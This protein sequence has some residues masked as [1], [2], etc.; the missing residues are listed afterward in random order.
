VERQIAAGVGR[1]VPETDAQAL[2]MAYRILWRLHA[3]G[4]LLTDGVLDMDSIGE[5]GRAF[6]LQE[7]GAP[8][9]AA[10][11][12]GV[13]QAVTAAAAAIDRLVTA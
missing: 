9:L 11:Q 6:V 2:L 7:A 1:H 3:A 4:R 13:E 5:G 12:A 10:L 8:D